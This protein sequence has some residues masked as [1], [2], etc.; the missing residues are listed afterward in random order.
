[1]SLVFSDLYDSLLLTRIKLQKCL[2]AANRLP[3]QKDL[4]TP[5]ESIDNNQTVKS[6]QQFLES[7]SSLK[8][9]FLLEN[10]DF[11]KTM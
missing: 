1:M 5:I 10:N 8:S 4:S 2:V 3:K 9:K 6:L 7:L 11:M